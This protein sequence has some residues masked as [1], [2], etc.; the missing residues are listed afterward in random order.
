MNRTTK[1]VA[2]VAAATAGVAAVAWLT[3]TAAGM[4]RLHRIAK[5]LERKQA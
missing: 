1:A 2:V 3:Y 4:L 5:R